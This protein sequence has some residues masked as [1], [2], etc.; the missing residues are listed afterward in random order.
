MSLITGLLLNVLPPATADGAAAAGPATAAAPPP[1]LAA[2]TR[3]PIV[4]APV[5]AKLTGVAPAAV[6]EWVIAW[7]CAAIT[8][9]PTKC[10]SRSSIHG[11]K[12]AITSIASPENR[13]PTAAIPLPGGADQ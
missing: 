13:L 3:P 8:S 12:Q 4:A 11:A 6:T 10:T 5:R 7:W 2:P 9:P 1:P